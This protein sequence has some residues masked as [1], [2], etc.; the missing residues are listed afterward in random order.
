MTD[1]RRTMVAAALGSLAGGA[2]GYL[3]FTERGRAFRRRLEP[4]L[5]DLAQE[6]GQLRGALTRA[7]SVAGPGWRIL[8]DV[9]SD[10]RYV[11]TRQTSPF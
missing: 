1:C 5:A 10:P 4:A 2:V 11:Q 7:S 3:F 6:L 8:H 9:M